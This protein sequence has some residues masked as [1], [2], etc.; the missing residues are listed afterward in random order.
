MQPINTAS[1]VIKIAAALVGLIASIKKLPGD[2]VTLH[3]L[4]FICLL[5]YIIADLAYYTLAYAPRNQTRVTKWILGLAIAGVAFNYMRS[6]NPAAPP[7]PR[8]PQ[9]AWIIATLL[10]WAYLIYDVCWC[11]IHRH[12]DRH[13][14][15]AA[16]ALIGGSYAWIIIP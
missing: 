14:V 1:S 6:Y 4:V 16:A 13:G 9:T 5:V 8:V 2:E 7:A 11:F 12:D 15:A 10:I 3:R